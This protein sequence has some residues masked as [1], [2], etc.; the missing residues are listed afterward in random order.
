MRSPLG[1]VPLSLFLLA[2]CSPAA[3]TSAGGEEDAVRAVVA[4]LQKAIRDKDGDALWNLLDADTQSDAERQARRARDDYA[5]ADDHGKKEMVRRSGLDGAVLAEL[6]ERS[7]FR[8]RGFAGKYGELPDSKVTRVTVTG[9]KATVE[10]VEP[11]EDRE[12]L[13]LVKAD[14][15]WKVALALPRAVAAPAEPRKNTAEEEE[16]V[17]KVVTRLRKA[18]KDKDYAAVWELLD[19]DTQAE[20]DKQARA[21]RE[22]YGT[23]HPSARQELEERH[24]LRPSAFDKLDGKGYVRSKVFWEEIEDLPGSTIGKVAVDDEEATVDYI[25]PGGKKEQ[26]TLVKED[27]RWKVEVD[28]PPAVKK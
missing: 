22:L 7:Y 17:L 19:E 16:A 9:D 10:Y 13:R 12:E 5:R 20:A 27:G 4:D 11:D 21:A 18:V 24:G 2:G 15:R 26:L 6:D 1:L 25:E 14:G 3:K 28:V 8:S 23:G